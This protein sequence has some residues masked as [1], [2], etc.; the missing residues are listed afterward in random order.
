MAT[1]HS[2]EKMTTNELKAWPSL[3]SLPTMAAEE[4]LVDRSLTSDSLP[5]CMSRSDKDSDDEMTKVNSM[6]K[7]LSMARSGGGGPPSPAWRRA[8]VTPAC[9]LSRASTA[10]CPSSPS[11]PAIRAAPGLED[12]V[13]QYDRC[14]LLQVRLQLL[15]LQEVGKGPLSISTQGREQL[16]NRE[17]VARA[18][19]EAEA[20]PA[21]APAE[22]VNENAEKTT[23]MLRN[24]PNQCTRASLAKFLATTDFA[25][26]FDLVYVPMDRTSGNNLGY[27]FI[28]FMEATSCQ[29]FIKAMN[30]AKATK[31]FPGSRSGKVLQCSY[32]KVQ[33]AEPYC[34]GLANAASKLCAMGD[35]LGALETLTPVPITQEPSAEQPAPAQFQGFRGDA[36][37]FV[38]FSACA[39]ASVHEEAIARA[40]AFSSKLFVPGQCADKDGK[41]NFPAETN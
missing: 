17:P 7:E 6:H 37:E 9:T 10:A 11:A 27:S 19:T 35:E 23:V 25:S 13:P 5:S 39:Q 29:H 36:P 3:G 14:L 2:T 32:A 38:P 8:R 4:E 33:G 16:R 41:E 15:S 30:G 21:A 40:R 20:Q 18:E 22:E 28:N 1:N 26:Q 24:L 31:C 12:V 34:L